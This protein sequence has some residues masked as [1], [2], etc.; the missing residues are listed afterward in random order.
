MNIF[1][2][3]TDM[4]ILSVARIHRRA[5]RL[6]HRFLNR[7]VQKIIKLLLLCICNYYYLVDRGI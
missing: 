3:M 5:I 4:R 2:E 6:Y 1:G 7:T